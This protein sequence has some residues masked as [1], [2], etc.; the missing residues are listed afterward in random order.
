[1]NDTCAKEP[2]VREWTNRLGEL[3][4][5]ANHSQEEL[6]KRVSPVMR[7]DP[8]EIKPESPPEETLVPMAAALRIFCRKVETLIERTQTVVSQLEI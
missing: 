7:N 5:V 2:Q 6:T 8:S 3:L 4:E 1:M